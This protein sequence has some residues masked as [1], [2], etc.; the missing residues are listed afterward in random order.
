MPILLLLVACDAVTDPLA[1]FDSEYTEIMVSLGAA[2]RDNARNVRNKEARQR[3]A[4]AE[5]AR[6]TFF[7]K[8]KLQQAISESRASALGTPER[9]KGE[10]YW[11]E[12]LQYSS[13]TGDEKTEETRLLGRLEEESSG[14]VS[15]SS[16]DGLTTVTLDRG[17][18]DISESAPTLDEATRMALYGEHIE[19]QLQVL[20]DD[21]QALITLRNSVAVRAGFSNYWELSLATNGLKP[22]QVES[23]LDKLKPIVE[24]INAAALQAVQEAAEETGLTVTPA[25]LPTLRRAAGL[26]SLG[27][28]ANNYFDAD[29]AEERI[30]TAFQDMGLPASGWQI[31][32]EPRR[33]ARP[34]AYG[35]P[36]RPPDNVAI[37]IS[38]D[39]RWSTWQYEALAH[40]GGHAIWWQLLPASQAASPAL[41][42]P[43]APWL[44]GFAGLFE[45]ILYEPSFTERYVPE[46]P[47]ALREPFQN[48]RARNVAAQITDGIVDTLVEKRLYEN[49][50]DLVA[51]TR[52]AAELRAE[53]TGLPVPGTNERGLTF[54]TALLSSLTWNYPGYSQNFLYAYAT[55]ATLF[56]GIVASVGEPVANSKVGPHL[57]E[58]LIQA[59]PG[60]PMPV[61]IRKMLPDASQTDALKR[62]LEVALTPPAPP[63]QPAGEAD[64][65]PAAE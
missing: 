26:I 58:N 6:V 17:W 9:I 55:E 16:P 19:H 41:W 43:P 31:H 8:K 18:D 37:V 56:E 53:L 24:P 36:I 44:E 5:K 49:P 12:S 1:E 27:D 52:Y 4:A 20:D 60:T 14:E 28:E 65:P 10:A 2:E 32:T 3:R 35:F 42:S 7:R 45:R 64:A 50:E 46:L 34:G 21:F 30:V 48:Q 33:Y 29:L 62:Y 51:L 54:D 11:L 15:W 61:R 47:A 39:R 13:W 40:E 22:A 59:D 57:Q 38:Q 63:A 25:N 23:F